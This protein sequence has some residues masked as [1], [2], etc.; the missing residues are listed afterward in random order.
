[1]GFITGL[2]KFV[3]GVVLGAATGAAVTTL[4]VTRNGQETVEKLRGVMN[5]VSDAF[6]SGVQEEEAK[7]EGRR[8]AL[9]GDA[10]EARRLKAATKKAEKE[11][12]KDNDKD[13]ALPPATQV[14]KADD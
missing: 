1:M 11:A 12:K 7:M 2:F 5:E 3:V 13:K 9:I 6:R 10:A 4:I 8:H 14:R